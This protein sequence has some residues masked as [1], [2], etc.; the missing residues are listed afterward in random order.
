MERKVFGYPAILYLETL[1]TN[2]VKT[3]DLGILFILFSVH[4]YK[5]GYISLSLVLFDLLELQV[6]VGTR[7]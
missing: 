7:N 1:N 5:H 6:T 3:I 2:F 4:I